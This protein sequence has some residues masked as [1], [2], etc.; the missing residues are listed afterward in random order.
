MKNLSLL[1]FALI[2]CSCTTKR[3][4]V[5][6]NDNVV[7]VFCGAFETTDP[8][9]LVN[10]LILRDWNTAEFTTSFD[11]I[12]KTKDQAPNYKPVRPASRYFIEKDTLYLEMDKGYLRYKIKDKNTLVGVGMWID[13]DELTRRKDY[14]N[15]CPKRHTLTADEKIWLRQSRLYYQAY[16]QN[17]RPVLERL[18]EEGYGPACMTVGLFEVKVA[19]NKEKG[20]ALLE[21]ACDL[22]YYG[23]YACFQLGDVLSDVGKAEAAKVAFQKACDGGH[24]VGCMMLNLMGGMKK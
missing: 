11:D 2:L 21:K 14:S 13:Q 1:L 23:H 19:Q 24:E 16:Y 4:F 8:K 18:C 6:V 12:Y 5:A 10:I 15:T 3:P 7:P 17:A 22:G 20:L 9:N